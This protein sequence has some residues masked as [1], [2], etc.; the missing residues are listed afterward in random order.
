[1]KSRNRPSWAREPNALSVRVSAGNVAAATAVLNQRAVE[2]GGKLVEV[3]HVTMDDTD[4]LYARV[5]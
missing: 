3:V 1:M 4:A 2:R 5:E